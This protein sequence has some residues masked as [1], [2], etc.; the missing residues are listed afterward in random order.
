M[1]MVGVQ[2][3]EWLKQWEKAICVAVGERVKGGVQ[4][5]LEDGAR[6][7]TAKSVLRGYND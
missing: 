4:L 6:E 5:R 1:Y 2:E 7:G 3:G